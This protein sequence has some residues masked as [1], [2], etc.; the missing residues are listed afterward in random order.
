M[1]SFQ[2]Q[3]RTKALHGP[4]GLTCIHACK[5]RIQPQ[6]AVLMYFVSLPRSIQGLTPQQHY[7]NSACTYKSVDSRFNFVTAFKYHTD[8]RFPQCTES[9]SNCC[10]F[11]N[12]SGSV[13][14]QH[15]INCTFISPHCKLYHPNKRTTYT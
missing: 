2:P 3:V 6:N 13:W 1:A 7:T 4:V 8:F 5:H 10:Q 9:S 14:E 15:S 12:N 11:C